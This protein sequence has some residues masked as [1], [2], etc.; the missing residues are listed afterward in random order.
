MTPCFLLNVFPCHNLILGQPYLFFLFV[1]G[2]FLFSLYYISPPNFQSIWIKFGFITYYLSAIFLFSRIADS[3]CR[4]TVSLYLS[5]FMVLDFKKKKTRQISLCF[6]FCLFSTSVNVGLPVIR[7][8][9]YL[10]DF[11]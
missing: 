6:C 8:F 5:K 1:F 9:L 11:S 2:P 4:I 7:G 10:H 3:D